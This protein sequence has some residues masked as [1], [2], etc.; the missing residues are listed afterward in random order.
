[1][2]G[3]T[4][5]TGAPGPID[6][7][8]IRPRPWVILLVDDEEDIL[9]TYQTLLESSIP[10]AKVL[11]AASG[12]QGLDLLEGERIDLIIADF[13]M[14]GMDGIEF[15]YQ[16]RRRFPHVPR[17]MF[18]AYATEELA[19]RAFVETFVGAV[20]AKTMDPDRLVAEVRRHLVY[21]PGRGAP[22]SPT[23]ANQAGNASG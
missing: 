5:G 20:L 4:I 16:A 12:R 13:K 2:K 11:T 17:L 7:P 8:D 6:R 9:E 21:E 18:T 22:T 3:D 1:M 23:K 19:R 15:L 14:P 10:Q